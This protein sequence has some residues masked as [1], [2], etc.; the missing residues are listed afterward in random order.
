MAVFISW[1]GQKGL[2]RVAGVGATP[3]DPIV[4][5]LSFYSAE[6]AFYV[7]CKQ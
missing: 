5:E 3:G 4:D 6:E 1:C 2:T 7:V